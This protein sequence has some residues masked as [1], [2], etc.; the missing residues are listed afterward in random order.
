MLMQRKHEVAMAL[1]R[2]AA[3]NDVFASTTNKR[4]SPAECVV[5]AKLMSEMKNP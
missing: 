1:R 5:I 3:G 2:K 4:K